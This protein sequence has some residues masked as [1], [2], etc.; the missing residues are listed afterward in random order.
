MATSEHKDRFASQRLIH[1]PGSTRTFARVLGGVFMVLV[2]CLFLPWTQNIRSSGTVTTFYPE[3][4][5]QQIHATIAGR[6][7]NWYV[8]EGQF[9][10]QG[11]TLVSLSEIKEKFFDPNLLDRMV[12]Q[13]QSKKSSLQSVKQK[14]EA[15]QQQ[16][17]ALQSGKEVSLQKAQ[18]KI[19]QA[20]NKV[21]IDSADLEAARIDLEVAKTRYQRDVEL[22]KKGLKSDVE[23]ESRKLKLQETE[24]KYTSQSNK[25]A[26]TKNEYLNA[27]IELNSIRAEYDDKIAKA[28]SDLNATLSYYYEAQAEISKMNSEYANVQIRNSYYHIV[29]P[30]SGFVVKTLVAGIGETIKEGDAIATILSKNIHKAVELYIK[31]MDMPLISVGR[32]VRLQFDG[33]PALVFSGWPDVS[34][35]TFGGQVAVIDKIDTKGLYRVLVV[36][37]EFDHPWPEVQI[38]SGVYGW[39]MMNDVPIW[40]ELW[41]Q[42]NGFPPDYK[43]SESIDLHE[44]NIYDKKKK[45]T[46]K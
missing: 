7:E 12:D 42:L 24:S 15:L 40:Y 8:R 14:S 34:F 39:A 38:G 32:H 26:L 13:I 18:N 27:R 44:D 43:G 22:N 25:L 36:P 9:V 6:I 35:G 4:R 33:W 1:T 19:L 37:D 30:Q 5:P 17:Q 41:R 45:G 23:V 11:D 28:S 46:S 20:R 10:H 2:L 16:V 29:A 31:P 3:E 21:S